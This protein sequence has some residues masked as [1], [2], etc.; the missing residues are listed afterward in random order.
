MSDL[1]PL[2][3]FSQHVLV[4]VDQ[5]DRR[6]HHLHLVILN[7]FEKDFKFLLMKTL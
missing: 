2:V 4:L 5:Q 7:I 3:Y 6:Y 1:H